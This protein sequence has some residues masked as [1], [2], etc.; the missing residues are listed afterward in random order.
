M[1]RNVKNVISIFG[2]TFQDSDLKNTIIPSWK[3]QGYFEIQYNNWH[4]AVVVQMDIFGNNIAIVQDCCHNKDYHNDMMQTQPFVKDSPNDKSDLVDWKLHNIKNLISGQ[5]LHQIIAESV[6][7]LLSENIEDEM[8][9][10]YRD[11]TAKFDKFDASFM[12]TGEGH[13]VHGW[14]IYVAVSEKSIR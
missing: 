8:A 4:F 2:K 11:S 6:D 5:R 1:L 13:Q 3:N 14:G 10:V 7:K 12:S 9:R